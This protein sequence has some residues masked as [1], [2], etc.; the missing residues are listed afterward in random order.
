LKFETNKVFKIKRQMM[1]DVP[2][3]EGK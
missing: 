2:T 3:F 1:I